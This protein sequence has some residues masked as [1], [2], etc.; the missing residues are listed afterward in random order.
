MEEDKSLGETV[1][2]NIGPTWQCGIPW[3]Q[4]EPEFLFLQWHFFPLPAVPREA[5][6][7]CTA[8]GVIDHLQ[9]V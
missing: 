9:D 4:N 6:E 1:I 2:K 7:S 5:I 3:R 8:H